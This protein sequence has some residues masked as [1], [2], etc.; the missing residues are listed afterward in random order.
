MRSVI[1]TRETRDSIYHVN[2][3]NR[4]TLTDSCIS[5]AYV[6]EPATELLSLGFSL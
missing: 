5:L 3:V 4:L 1:D 2:T 6:A